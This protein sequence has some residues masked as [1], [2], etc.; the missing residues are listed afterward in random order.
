MSTD[1]SL[2][3][4]ELVKQVRTR[5]YSLEHCIESEFGNDHPLQCEELAHAR[6][7]LVQ[8]RLW[9]GKVLAA[10]GEATP[11]S[12]TR[13]VNPATELHVN[14]SWLW[15][16]GL[17]DLH[18]DPAKVIS[19]LRSTISELLQTVDSMACSSLHSIHLYQS[20]G[21]DLELARMWLGE[22]FTVMRNNRDGLASQMRAELED[23][24]VSAGVTG[25]E[26][27][28]ILTHFLEYRTGALLRD[29][30]MDMDAIAHIAYN[31]TRA[32][33]QMLGDREVPFWNGLPEMRR[34]T[35]KEHVM[36]CLL[37]PDADAEQL[38][39]HWMAGK[40][41]DGWKYAPEQD[42]DAKEDHRLAKF[43]D[44]PV[45]IQ[46]SYIIGHRFINV[47]L[48]NAEKNVPGT[49]AK[50]REN[51]APHADLSSAPP[52]PVEAEN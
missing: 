41:N 14:H 33:C 28:D 24:F 15:D 2:A 27:L 7:A 48:E 51:V 19:I 4:K 3:P 49:L 25:L 11:Y 40:L 31:V 30:T 44:L 13:P 39:G 17:I 23:L 46:T 38:H 20:A 18:S 10:M 12:E 16:L 9:L 32:Y 43:G 21:R 26:R 8:A 29:V 47:C 52:A 34:Q 22:V 45:E 42:I 35:M 6:T 36:F 1:T 50:W 5:I 37:N